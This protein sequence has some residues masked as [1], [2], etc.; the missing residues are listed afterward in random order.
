M[1][2]KP[3]TKRGALKFYTTPSSEIAEAVRTYLDAHRAE[4]VSRAVANLTNYVQRKKR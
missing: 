2:S 3:S 4:L 1:P